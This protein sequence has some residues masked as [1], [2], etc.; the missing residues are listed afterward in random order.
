MPP[1]GHGAGCRFALAVFDQGRLLAVAAIQAIKCR[2]IASTQRLG[3]APVRKPNWKNSVVSCYRSSYNFC[4]E[5]S[6]ILI[7]VRTNIPTQ[8]V[9]RRE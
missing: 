6:Q 9:H 7:Q 8:G 1:P 2:K 3:A 5:S 4:N